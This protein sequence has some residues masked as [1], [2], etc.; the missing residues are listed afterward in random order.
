[1]A[2]LWTDRSISNCFPIEAELDGLGGFRPV[3]VVNEPGQDFGN[4]V[5]SYPRGLR[6]I[7]ILSREALN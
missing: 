3:S 7:G 5:D 4:Y 6:T 2:A 1:L